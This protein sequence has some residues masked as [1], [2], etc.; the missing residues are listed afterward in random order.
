MM[1][2]KM[3]VKMM[4]LVVMMVMMVLEVIM[5]LMLFGSNDI[6]AVHNGNIYHDFRIY[7]ILGIRCFAYI[8]LSVT[9]SLSIQVSEMNRVI[10]F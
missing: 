5:V 9:I 10:N 6:Y 4:F 8:T 2:V 1:I 3:V 7:A